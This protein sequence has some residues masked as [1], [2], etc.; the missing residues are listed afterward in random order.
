MAGIDAPGSE[1]RTPR[2]LPLASQY[3][4]LIDPRIGEN[5]GIGWARLDD[6]ILRIEYVSQDVFHTGQCK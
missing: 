1:N 3:T 6:V 5:S 2:G 4:L